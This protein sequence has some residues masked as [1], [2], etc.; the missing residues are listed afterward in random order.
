MAVDGDDLYIADTENH[1]VR[2]ANLSGRTIQ[3]IAGTGEQAMWGERV[4]AT[5]IATALSSPWDVELVGR[6]LYIALAGQHA[7]FSLNL[8]N[9][10]ISRY[11]GSGYEARADGLRRT[12]SFAQPSGLAY[13]DE[14][15]FVADSEISCIRAIDFKTQR[16]RT[17]VG[18]DLFEFGDIDGVGDAARLQHPL[19]VAVLGGAVFVADSYNHKIR[20]LN[21]TTREINGFAGSGEA[22]YLDGML[23]EAKFNEPGGLCSA[24][25]KLYVADTNNHRI[26]LI[27][28]D[29]GAV[30]T[31]ALSGL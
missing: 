13:S 31:L 30:T 9:G 17:L 19:G 15:I 3:T 10:N 28:A 8:E 23:S 2:L 16:V 1:V 20:R 27:D 11:A 18:G 22:G 6:N 24:G 26:R 4:G 12:A 5:A 21:P 25:G 7:I 29:A 14:M